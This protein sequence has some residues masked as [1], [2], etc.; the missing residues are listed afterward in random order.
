MKISPDVIAHV[1]HGFVNTLELKKLSE[2]VLFVYSVRAT[3]ERLFPR[4]YQVVLFQT[5]G[6]GLVKFLS[7][8]N[9]VQL[10]VAVVIGGAFNK[11]VETFVSSFITPT[12]GVFGGLPEFKSLFFKINESRFH[13]GEFIDVL[14]SFLLIAVLVYYLFVVPTLWLMARVQQKKLNTER[15]CPICISKIDRAARRCPMCTSKV[16]PLVDDEAALITPR[17]SSRSKI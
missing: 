1:P 11:L 4:C 5:M 17:T 9:F 8:G 15:N 7:Q 16:D 12:F 14:I 6:S 2:A 3:F 13:Y 10:A